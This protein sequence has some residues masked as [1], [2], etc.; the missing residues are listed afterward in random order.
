MVLLKVLVGDPCP[1]DSPEIVTVAKIYNLP[2]MIRAL[3]LLYST[4]SAW[5]FLIFAR[6]IDGPLCRFTYL[7]PG[8][9]SLFSLSFS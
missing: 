5:D 1:L 7:D 2:G 8:C 9:P 4:A 6:E 3:S